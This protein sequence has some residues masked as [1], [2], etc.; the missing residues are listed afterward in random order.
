MLSADRGY[1]WDEWVP[2]SRVLKLNE[3]GFAKQ[4]TLL[5]AQSSNKRANAS[6]APSSAKTGAAAASSSG[7]GAATKKAEGKKRGRES[8]VDNVR[9]AERGA[10]ADCSQEGDYMK[11]PEVKIVIPDV[12]KLQLVDDWEYVTKNNQVRADGP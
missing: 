1:R 6:P 7:R 5:A 3:A 10:Q 8:G 2:E 9:R 12:L 4:R 11:R